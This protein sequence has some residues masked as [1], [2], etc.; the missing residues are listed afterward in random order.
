[1]DIISAEQTCN[2]MGFI[3]TKRM[4]S[5]V[6]GDP[7]VMVYHVDRIGPPAMMQHWKKSP[8]NDRLSAGPDWAFIH[9]VNDLVNY[10]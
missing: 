6:F 10:K 4:E 2:Q 1:M 8:F 3:F 7:P 9:W 5:G